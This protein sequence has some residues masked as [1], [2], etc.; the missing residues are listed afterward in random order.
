M[1]T[2]AEVDAMQRVLALAEA[3]RG[4]VEPNPLVGC[5]LLGP[6]G[7]TLGEGA[8][9]VFG[10]PHAEV[11]A[12][13]TAA[14]AGRS[15]RGATAVVTLEPCCHHGKTGPCTEALIGAGVARVVVAMR[16]P[17]PRV[18]G[19][20][21][22][23]LEAAGVEVVVLEEGGLHD[24][25]VELNAPF[26]KRITRG[27]PYVTLKWAQTVD[28]RTATRTGDSRWISNPESRLA[29]HRLRARSDAVLV[30]VGTAIADDPSLTVRLP[31][32][33]PVPRTP[34]RLVADRSCRLPAASKLLH[35]GAA[36]TR[37]LRGGLADELRSLSAEGM[38][39]VLCEGGAGLAAALL[40]DPAGLVDELQVFIGPKLL[41]DAG[42]VPVL[43]AVSDAGRVP[44]LAMQNARPLTL[45]ACERKGADVWLRYRL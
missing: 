14:D 8:H 30:G 4:Y 43:G 13:Q 29:V 25:A 34:V 22:A 45:A 7:E 11:H 15:V 20:G 5:V 26:V 37:V 1:I 40:A 3:W 19:G 36:E 39:H 16:D 12:L 28:G 21:I 41:N 6:S 33:E 18:T 42:A 44:V 17:D 9:E 24:A 32:D 23:Q 31:E 27:L 35:D 10:G 38:T 2:P